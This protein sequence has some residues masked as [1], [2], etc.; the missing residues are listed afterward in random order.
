MRVVLLAPYAPGVRV[1]EQGLSRDALERALLDSA[2]RRHEVKVIWARVAAFMPIVRGTCPA[3][4][5]KSLF[6]ASG[7]YVTCANLDCPNPGA[8]SDLLEPTEEE[9][10]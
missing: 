8:A 9:Q 7:G 4:G 1:E 6:L 2:V 10:G 3:C 5:I